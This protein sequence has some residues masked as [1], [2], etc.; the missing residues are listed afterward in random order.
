[1]RLCVQPAPARA[2]PPG[3]LLARLLSRL[4]GR[5]LGRFPVLSLA[6][7]VSFGA[8]AATARA[9]GAAPAA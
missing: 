1:M 8:V 2:L 9:G 6:L 7:A 4:L 3:R 5:L